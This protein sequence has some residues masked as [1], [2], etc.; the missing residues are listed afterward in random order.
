MNE[1]TSRLPSALRVDSQD[2][3]DLCLV[4]GEPVGPIERRSQRSTAPADRSN[5]LTD[6]QFTDAVDELAAASRAYNGRGSEYLAKRAVVLAAYRAAVVA[7]LDEA[8]VK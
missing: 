1:N 7:L 2:G 3:Q 4:G 8:G 5:A 6:K